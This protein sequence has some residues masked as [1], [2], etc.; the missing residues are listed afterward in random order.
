MRFAV[1]HPGQVEP[2]LVRGDVGDI[3]VPELID[4]GN[5]EPLLKQV[6]RFNDLGPFAFRTVSGRAHGLQSL[7][8][9]EPFDAA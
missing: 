3:D 9:H 7:T 4:A 5:L 6:A 2:A 1:N 8:P